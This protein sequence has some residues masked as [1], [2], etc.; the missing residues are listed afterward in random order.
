MINE[1]LIHDQMSLQEIV[2]LLKVT[3]NCCFFFL[4]FY[5]HINIRDIVIIKLIRL[6][7]HGFLFSVSDITPIVY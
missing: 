6:N 1:A 2:V 3:F 7:G 4:R 5:I